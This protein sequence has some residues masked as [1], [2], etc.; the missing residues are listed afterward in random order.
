MKKW[1]C[2]LLALALAAAC[3]LPVLAE[4]DPAVVTVNG[5]VVAQS[6][7]DAMIDSVSSR[8]SQYGIDGTDESVLEVIRQSALQQLVDDRLITQ[9]MTAQGFYDMTE[10]EEAAIAASAQ[11]TLN[12]LRQQAESYF[13]S[14]L[15]GQEDAGITAVDLAEAYLTGSGYTLEYMENHCR[16]ALASQKYEQWLME[17]EPEITQE[18]IQAGYEQ[19]VESSKDAYAQD[20]SAFET[21]LASGQEVWYRPEG[22]RAVLQIMLGAEGEDDESKLAS[23]KEKTD[24]I[25]ARLAGGE[26]FTSL[27]AAYGEDSAF[28]SEAFYETGYQ[29]HKDSILWEDAFIQAAFGADMQAPGDYSQPVVFGDNVHILYYLKDVPAGAVSLTDDLSEALKED[30]YSERVNSKMEARLAELKETAEI[31]YA[32]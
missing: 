21:A 3:T 8:M 10:E 5:D 7:L 30:V 2:I 26:P 14:Y 15:D 1:I 24:D 17:G 6:E 16:N 19:R 20:I 27:I 11:E 29:V 12:S 22:Y 13:T 32:Q 25:Y 9:D 18:D 4:D 23:V 31:I 28:D